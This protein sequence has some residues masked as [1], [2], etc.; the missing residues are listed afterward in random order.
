[1]CVPTE[2]IVL[3]LLRVFNTIALFRFNKEKL[4]ARAIVLK[5]LTTVTKLLFLLNTANVCLHLRQ[6]NPSYFPQQCETVI[7]PN[8]VADMW[9]KVHVEL[10]LG[11]DELMFKRVAAYTI[12][13]FSLKFVASL[14]ETFTRHARKIAEGLRGPSIRR[15]KKKEAN[16]LGGR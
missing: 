4:R 16:T 11:N 6:T 5:N 14:A 7:Q 2:K 1:M 12:R 9:K 3:Q 15:I 10:I 13:A 8:V